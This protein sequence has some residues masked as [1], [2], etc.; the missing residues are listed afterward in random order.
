MESQQIKKVL[1]R[2]EKEIKNVSQ[3]ERLITMMEA[4]SGDDEIVDSKRYKTE[5][6]EERGS[7][8]I[9]KVMTGIPALDKITEGF[10]EGNLIVISGP[11]K[12]GKT[13]LC[14]TFTEN[15]ISNKI[16]CL[17]LPFDTPAEELILRF[18]KPPIFYLPRRNPIEKK[19]T[20]VESKI[21]EGVAKYN[22]KVIFID[23]IGRLT[24]H[25]DAHLNYSTELQSIVG[26]L[27]EM[28]IRWKIIII[29]NHHIRKIH[30]NT[31]PLLSDLKDSSGVAQD[32]DMV[33]MIWRIKNKTQFGVEYSDRSIISVQSNRRT[34]KLGT[35]KL[36]HKGDHFEEVKDDY[37]NF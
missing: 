29:V 28:A 11:T 5:M 8:E 25:T 30:T 18:K 2:L 20:W 31:T 26:E 15:F 10:W 37:E 22:I 16:Q 13:T 36:L 24:K 27:K 21:I 9:F 12:E 4:Y 19:L 35:V 6:D 7:T 33:I 1:N 34:G 14:Q 23:H 3:K 32:S 17:W